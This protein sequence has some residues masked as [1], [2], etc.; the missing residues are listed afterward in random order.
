M[1]VSERIKDYLDSL[2]PGNSALIEKIREEALKDRIPILRRDTEE[3]LKTLLVMKRPRRILEIGTA[4]GYS[5]LVMASVIEEDASITTL[6]I[7]EADHRKAV[8]NIALA[9]KTDQITCLLTDAG[10]YLKNTVCEY[11]F[12]FL[13]AA[14][15]QY[16]NWLPDI[17][18]CLPI[19]GVL[20]SDNVLLEGTVAESRFALD[21]RERTAHERMRRFLFEITHRE[22]LQTSVL[23]AGDGASISIRTR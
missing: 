14:K 7:G 3:L 18:R 8:N 13:D 11:D 6:E 2:S 20:L 15:A 21:R 19:G 23:P 16:I 9:G 22:D 4:V 17:V 5:A 1:I 10:E 12:I